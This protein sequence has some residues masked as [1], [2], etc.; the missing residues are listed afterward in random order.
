MDDGEEEACYIFEAMQQMKWQQSEWMFQKYSWFA[1]YLLA[2]EVWQLGV[3]HRVGAYCA[4]EGA[5][6]SLGGA[7]G[8]SLESHSQQI[9]FNLDSARKQA[10]KI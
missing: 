7:D 3:S 5:T 10:T 6:D 4:S 9:L 2:S 1:F 8:K